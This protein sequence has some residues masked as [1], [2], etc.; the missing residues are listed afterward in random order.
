MV[1]PQTAI[2]PPA[3]DIL[4]QAWNLR[5]G[6]RAWEVMFGRFFLGGG[7]TWSYDIQGC[8]RTPEHYWGNVRL[9]RSLS[10]DAFDT[11]LREPGAGCDYAF[12]R[13]LRR[14]QHWHQESLPF[15]GTP[16][17]VAIPK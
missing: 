9:F 7:D 5:L 10:D 8:P 11:P 16:K 3:W 15:L 6:R 13:H 1:T 12:R 14:L 4:R 17:M 2:P